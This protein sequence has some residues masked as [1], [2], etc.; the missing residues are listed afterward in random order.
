MKELQLS[1][2][3]EDRKTLNTCK[4]EYN[5]HMYN[6]HKN[7]RESYDIIDVDNPDFEWAKN[8]SN[9]FEKYRRKILDINIQQ[10]RDQLVKEKFLLN[11]ILIEIKQKI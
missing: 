2:S 9:F 7:F 5:N 1:L 10:T 6:V 11:R 4:N 3:K 8:A